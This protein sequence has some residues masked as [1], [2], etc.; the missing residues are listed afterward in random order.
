MADEKKDQ[1]IMKMEC[2]HQQAW[3]NGADSLPV[4]GELAFCVWCQKMEI[5]AKVI[6]N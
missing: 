4:A 5:I 3:G 2:G 6:P 1:P